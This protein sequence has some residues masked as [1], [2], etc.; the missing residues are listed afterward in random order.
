MELMVAI[1]IITML[2][3]ISI[4]YSRTAQNQIILAKEE[5]GILGL[6]I[7]AK[8]LSVAT[9]GG[10]GSPCGYGVHFEGNS[11]ILFKEISPA[12]DP[13]CLDINFIYSSDEKFQEMK[14]D[15]A[16]KFSFLGLQDI[17]FIPP[18]PLVVIDGDKNKAEGII[19]MGT[20]DGNNEKSIKVTNG[21]QITD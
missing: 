6:I 2:S 20:I 4:F 17:V 12:N 21:G 9:F 13:N 16:V 11:A 15:P 7:R 18:Q 10:L 1:G 8:T 14:L 19:T 3:S 5:A